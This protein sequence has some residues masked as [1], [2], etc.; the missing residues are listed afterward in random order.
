MKWLKKKDRGEGVSTPE[1]V[2]ADVPAMKAAGD[3]EGLILLMNETKD[4][5]VRGESVKALGELGDTRAVEPLLKKFD[6]H[7][8]I[9][10]NMM[11]AQ[12]EP[13]MQNM[14]AM[15]MSAAMAGEMTIRMAEALAKMAD[16]RVGGSFEAVLN[17][18]T[19]GGAAD[20][21]E[22]LK[23]R[24]GGNEAVLAATML[25]QVVQV[26]KI[27]AQTVGSA[28]QGSSFEEPPTA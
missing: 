12:K 11:L 8:G 5:G 10:R 24:G 27:A 21:I 2:T 7:V 14:P 9:L 4:L 16:N 1:G 22:H 19:L 23:A 17:D 15:L 3:V 28:N 18:E 25:S 20:E 26:R 6:G 13:A